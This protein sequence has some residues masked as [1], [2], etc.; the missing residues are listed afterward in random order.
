M[1]ERWGSLRP[2]SIPCRDPRAEIIA[3]LLENQK[4]KKITLSYK[5]PPKVSVEKNLKKYIYNNKPTKKIESISICLNIVA[6]YQTHAVAFQINIHL[7]DQ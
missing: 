5:R 2:Q 3:N 6:A 7:F 4:Q 1:F